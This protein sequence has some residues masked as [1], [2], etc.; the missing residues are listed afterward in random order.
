MAALK[1]TE[2]DGTRWRVGRRWLPWRPR[3]RNTMDW[4]PLD[5]TDLASLVVGLV[6]AVVLIVVLGIV[7]LAIELIVALLFVV[8]VLF[9]RFVLGR[10]WTIEAVGEDGR[11]IRKQ[12][13]GWRDSGDEVQRLADQI[14]RGDANRAVAAAQLVTES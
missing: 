9:L 11:R 3:P 7:L 8:V 2:P 5:G 12:V 6:L 4:M 14:T 1:V 10:P 13:A